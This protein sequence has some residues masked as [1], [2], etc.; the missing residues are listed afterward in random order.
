MRANGTQTAQQ[1]RVAGRPL[2]LDS[3]VELGVRISVAGERDD[4]C[5][6]SVDADGEGRRVCE[7]T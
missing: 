7:H 6:L 1:T 2:K 3:K 5:T 4:V